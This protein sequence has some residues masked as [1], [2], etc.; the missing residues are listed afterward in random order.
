MRIDQYMA[1]YWPEHSRSVWQKHIKTG[2]VSVNNVLTTDVSYELK[3]DDEVKL[4]EIPEVQMHQEELPVIYEDNHVLVIN[5]PTGILTHA[6]GEALEEFTVADFVRQKM[7]EVEQGNRPGIVHRLDR[8]TSGVLI[9]AKD[10][11]TKQYLQ[12]QFQDRKTKKSYIAVV[13]GFPKNSEAKIDLPIS[14]NPKQPSSFRV[15]P[16]GKSAQTHYEVIA[17]NKMYSVLR[18]K[19]I[20]GRTHQLRVHMA[21]IGIPILGDTLYGGGKSPIKRVCLHAESLEITI[22]ESQRKVFT[23]PLPS[24][25]QGLY[26]KICS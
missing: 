4:T 2:I 15:D 26:D 10:L 22:P 14:R 24:D 7:T 9:A 8:T 12:K 16:K 25:L 5:K 21:Y 20:T 18:L 19:P 11:A 23:A 1:L 6:K 17:H 13:N 3:E